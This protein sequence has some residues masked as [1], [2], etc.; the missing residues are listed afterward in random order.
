[1]I[2]FIPKFTLGRWSVGL[3]IAFFVLLAIGNFI[4]KIQGPRAD[5]TFFD[6]PILSIPMLLAGASG[7]AAFFT[8]IIAIVKKKERAV[9][10]IVSTLLGFF[11]LIFVIGEF[12]FP[13]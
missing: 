3:I 6:N 9:L 2:I 12:I 4:V 8:G 1:M 7:I 13:H 11:I 5:Q 10:V